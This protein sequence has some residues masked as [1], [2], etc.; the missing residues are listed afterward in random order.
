[1]WLLLLLL[2]LMVLVLMLMLN[3]TA[4]AACA[5]HALLDGLNL[6]HQF[7][8]LA[9]NKLAKCGMTAAPLCMKE[10]QNAS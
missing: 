10:N 2:L 5:A 7:I 1:L 9:V 3:M 4:L 8:K 6:L